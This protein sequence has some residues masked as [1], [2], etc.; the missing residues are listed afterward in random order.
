M[1][2]FAEE[3]A[4][5]AGELRRSNIGADI[6]EAI[7]DAIQEASSTHYYFNEIQGL[8]FPTVA[9]TEYYTDMFMSQIDNMYITDGGGVRYEVFPINNDRLNIIT[10]S[11]TQTNSRPIRYARINQDI[12]FYPIPDAV[13]E[14]FMD[15]FGRL[16]PY[17]LTNPTDTNAWLTE[18]ERLIR[19]LA[20]RNVLRDVIKD[21]NEAAVQQA[22][23]DDISME[24]QASTTQRIGTGQLSS[25][26]W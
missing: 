2:T 8:N 15:G 26:R 11:A 25:T 6:Q 18:G 17:P 19:V 16:T 14:V 10:S 1:A 7:N 9:A 4:R 21:Y 5:I 12:R 20:K 13:Y 23:A 3:T 24:L 22:I